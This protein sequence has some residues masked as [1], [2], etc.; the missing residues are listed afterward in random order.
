MAKYDELMETM[1]VLGF[2]EEELGQTHAVLM[3]VLALGNIDFVEDSERDGACVVRSS[4]A[5]VHVA[6]LCGVDP[7]SLAARLTAGSFHVR[8]ESVRLSTLMSLL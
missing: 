5:V 2:D 4:A 8:G 3:S 1:R 6:L 7:M